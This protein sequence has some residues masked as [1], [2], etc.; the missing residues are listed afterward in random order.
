MTWSLIARD[1]NG[2]L[3]VAVASR[4]FAVGALCPHAASGVGALSTQALVNPLYARRRARGDGDATSI[5]RRSSR[6]LT[7]ADRGSRPPAAAPDRPDGRIAAHTGAACIDWCGHRAGRGFSV[8]GNMLAGPRVLDDTAAAFEANRALPF[9]LRLIAAMEAGEAAGGDKRGK[10]AAALIVCTTE[11]YPGA[12]SARRRPRRADRRIAAPVREEPRALPAVRRLP[13][14][15]RRSGRHHRSRRH[16]GRASS[17]SRRRARAG[18]ERRERR[19]DACL[20]YSE[21]RQDAARA[22]ATIGRTPHRTLGGFA[23]QTGRRTVRIGLA[24]ATRP[25]RW[26]R[27]RRRRRC[28][29]AWPRI[30]TSSI[31]R[32]RARSSGASSSR[33][34]ATSCSTSTRSSPSCPQLAT[35]VRVVGGQQGA[36]AQAAARRHVPRR[37]EARRRRRQVQHRAAQDDGG[38]QSARRARAGDDASTSSIRRRCGSTCR[39]RSR[40]CSPSSPTAP[41]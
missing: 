22:V 15:A 18:P 5:P 14:P 9:A 37:R 11:T 30:P 7:G 10:Q 24:L 2:A 27:P 8:A 19:R 38:L 33:R 23:M 31:R 36:D 6:A 35:V 20:C 3:G 4:F 28:A 12:R 26:R 13:A 29:S 16:R 32:S 40:R 34:C 21:S 25:P 17:A 41:G 39:R 1:A